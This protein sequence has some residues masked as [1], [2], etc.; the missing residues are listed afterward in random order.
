V[1]GCPGNKVW[2]LTF[3]DGPSKFTPHLLDILKAKGIK[4]MFMMMGGNAVQHPDIV[5][6]V[7]AEGHEI[8]SHTW[9]HPHLM[10]LTNEQIIAEV[11]ST[12]DVI[13]N[14]TG[15][16]RPRYFRPPY[17]E[18]DARVKAILAAHHLQ[19]L[20]WNMDTTD[21]A[22]IGA[23]KDPKAIFEAFQKALTQDTQLNPFKNPGFI[24]LQHD[25]FIQSIDQENDVIDMLTKNGFSLQTVPQCLNDPTPYKNLQESAVA[26]GASA[27]GGASPPPVS[28]SGSAGM[29]NA[30]STKSPAASARHGSVG[31][32]LGISLVVAVAG[33]TGGW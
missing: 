6:R 26:R 14:L 3:D 28:G 22:T 16:Y 17:G 8:G 11:K 12:E 24:S 1:Y 19:P 33:L 15:G 30:T 32:G 9:S 2:A 18:A 5:K 4:A 29:S 25:I 21:Y 23:K 31:V 13:A 27:G 10:S 7:W 20:L